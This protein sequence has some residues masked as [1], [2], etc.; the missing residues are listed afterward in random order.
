MSDSLTGYASSISKIPDSTIND[1]PVD[2]GSIRPP[3][4][5]KSMSYR[6]KPVS[7]VEVVDAAPKRAKRPSFAD[8]SRLREIGVGFVQLRGILA[9]SALLLTISA[10]PAFVSNY[11]IDGRGSS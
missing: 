9:S 2:S 1:S 6:H 4:Q 10:I 11:H 5:R 3:G 8:W 7:A